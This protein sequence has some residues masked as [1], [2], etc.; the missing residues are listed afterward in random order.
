MPICGRLKENKMEYI[1][2]SI[3]CRCKQP[4]II[5]FFVL[6]TLFI[7]SQLKE[8]KYYPFEKESDMV[9]VGD[10]GDIEYIYKDLSSDD[11]KEIVLN[12][13]EEKINN[14]A[15]SPNTKKMLE[16]I[17]KQLE[18]K[19][20]DE[21]K[22]YY[23]QTDHYLLIDSLISNA[24]YQYKTIEDANASVMNKNFNYG[25]QIDV[26]KKFITYSQA[27]LAFILL[28][29][30]FFFVHDNHNPQIEEARRITNTR[31]IKFYIYDL[32]VIIIPC[33]LYTYF[34]GIALNV[35]SF[36]KY[37][38]AGYDI[39]YCFTYPKYLTIFIPTLLMCIAILVFLYRLF[40]ENFAATI[41]VYLAWVILNITPKAF[42]IP[43]IIYRLIVIQRLDDIQTSIYKYSFAQRIIVLFLAI[44]VFT[45]GYNCQRGRRKT[46]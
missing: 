27:I 26:Q 43:K 31:K 11:I 35:Y 33:V 24:K 42:S 10:L 28:P 39:H 18:V 16:D 6:Y 15:T 8:I 4:F 7:L 46:L 17:K 45:V 21:V 32:L 1:K 2:N 37:K 22:E 41:P 29:Y 20:I 38:N 12:D 44:I 19:G 30:V 36:M 9:S 34:L 23:E 13:V 40:G 3:I 25:Y 14:S 5:A